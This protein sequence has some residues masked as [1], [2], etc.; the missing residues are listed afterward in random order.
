MG[1][2]YY[3]DEK[4]LRSLEC[5]D[6]DERLHI[7]KQS[8]G[9][10]FCFQSQTAIFDPAKDGEEPRPRA[11]PLRSVKDFK[12][13]LDRW[14]LPHRGRIVDEY[15]KELSSEEFWLIVEASRHR[16]NE[17]GRLDSDSYIDDG[18]DFYTR[19]FS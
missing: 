19:E 8:S 1:T 12:F 6:E 9:W 4:R 11:I 5:G 13:L 10:V 18:F 15:G 16:R 14:L 3:V 7:G 2:N 17:A